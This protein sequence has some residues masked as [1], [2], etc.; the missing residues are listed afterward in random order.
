MKRSY[1]EYFQVPKNG[2]VREKVLNARLTVG[3]LG[4]FLCLIVMSI[5]A[6]AY[7]THSVTSKTESLRSASFD[8]SLSVTAPSG[9]NPI[10]ETGAD[11][12]KVYLKKGVPY[13]FSLQPRGT[14]STGFCVMT[15]DGISEKFHTAQLGASGGQRTDLLVFDL[16]LS[17]DAYVV[18]T[19]TWGTSSYFASADDP[20]VAE[21]YI[22]DGEALS[23]TV[24]SAAQ[25]LGHPAN[26]VETLPAAGTDAT[27]SEQE[28]SSGNFPLDSDAVI[29]GDTPS[30]LISSSESSEPETV[31]DATD[32][33]DLS[34]SDSYEEVPVSSSDAT[35]E[36]ESDDFIDSSDSTE[37][38]DLPES[39]VSSSSASE[40][41]TSDE[42]VP[43]GSRPVQ[44][45]SNFTVDEA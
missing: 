19:P 24:D 17:E 23:L 1:V 9:E 12:Y 11:A 8:V 33:A 45:E 6:Y 32:S 39:S 35:S 21:V 10:V 2:K 36:T 26:M 28:I 31:T 27:S 43:S 3:I 20:A 13:S 30:D 4:I 25:T 38:K 22:L 14:A 41:E 7:F 29:D 5:T 42:T 44:N 34:G 37:L 15:V 18:F 40:A 16:L